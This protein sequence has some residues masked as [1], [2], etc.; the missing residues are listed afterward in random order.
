MKTDTTVVCGIRPTGVPHLGNYFSFIRDTVALQRTH[1]CFVFV[2]DY[3]ALTTCDDPHAL[4]TYT[5]E[6]AIDLLASG[7]DPN[8]CVLFVQSDVPEVVEIALLLSMVASKGELERCTTF[9]EKARSQPDNVN[10]GLLGYPVLMAADVLAHRARLVP[11]GQD[12]VQHLEMARSIAERFNHRFGTSLPLPEPLR[13]NPIRVPGL[14]GEEKMGKSEANS[15]ALSDEPEVI[16][17]KV[18]RATTDSD[19][20]GPAFTLASKPSVL[21]LHPY[22]STAEEVKRLEQEM[23]DG[24]AGY[25]EAKEVLADNIIRLLAPIRER[26]RLIEGRDGYLEDVLAEGARRARASAGR[27][28]EVLREAMGLPSTRRAQLATAVAA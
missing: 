21:S 12:Q 18:M 9:K 4:R 26:R 28:L 13:R 10:L 5:R 7:F 23:R 11:V 27:T 22:V 8:E 14:D 25:K 15:I 1:Q 16:R 3:H 17:R 24:R 20:I 6:L 19:P 2:A